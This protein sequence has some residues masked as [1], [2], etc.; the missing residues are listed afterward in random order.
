MLKKI[1]IIEPL[2]QKACTLISCV[3]LEYGLN[4]VKGQIMGEKVPEPDVLWKTVP[5]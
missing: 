1:Y 2:S 5:F 3:A 4:R